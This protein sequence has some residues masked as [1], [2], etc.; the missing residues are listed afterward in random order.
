MTRAHAHC[1]GQQTVRL[2]ATRRLQVGAT[3]G[4]DVP[5]PNGGVMPLL[6]AGSVVTSQYR[7]ALVRADI[8]AVYIDDALGKGIDIEEP[9]TEA[10]RMEAT[11]VVSG[12]FDALATGAVK[13]VPDATLKQLQNVAA[14]MAAEI[15]ACDDAT[16]ALT[17]LASADRYTMQHSL[18]VTVLGLLVG[19]RLFTDEGRIDFRGERTFIKLEQA[20]TRL[21]LGLLLHDI[22]KLTIPKEILHKTG[23][24]TPAEWKVMK[25][26]PMTGVEMLRSDLIGPTSKAVVRS[27]HERWDGTGYPDA[28]PAAETH[29][30]ARIAAVA[31]VFDAV[32]SER[33][34]SEGAP[35]AV[36]LEAIVSGS[37]T[38]FDPEVVGVFRRV[39]V[40]YPPGS[41]IVLADGRAGVVV[42]V[43]DSQF[44]RP[45]IRIGFAADG[46]PVEPYEIDLATDGDVALPVLTVPQR[47]AA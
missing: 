4:R 17:D 26:H 37:G 3:L 2:T 40:P 11:R 38:A 5:N 15:A 43:R 45:L 1:D 12:A 46:N 7:D 28:K 20:L 18:D 16:L 6:R 39:V 24:L 30:F 35:Q 14:L 22:G 29:Q 21:G 8:Q 9:L 13:R 34:Y 32:T 19:R 27:H 31:D 23:P 41:E 42:A 47:K 10:T 36:G 25:R 33:T 44:E